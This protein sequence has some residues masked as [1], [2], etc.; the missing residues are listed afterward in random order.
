[1]TLKAKG[2][3]VR[4]IA[5][6]SPAPKTQPCR[7]LEPGEARRSWCYSSGCS[8]AVKADFEKIF[9]PCSPVAGI[10]IRAGRIVDTQAWEQGRF[11]GEQSL[12]GPCLRADQNAALYGQAEQGAAAPA[13]PVVL[14]CP[15][16]ANPAPPGAESNRKAQAGPDNLRT[17]AWGNKDTGH[18]LCKGYVGAPRCSSGAQQDAEEESRG[19]H[20]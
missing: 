8:Q 11:K 1:M 4:S 3:R 20:G 15:W 6:C 18:L 17:R 10:L 7:G 13:L 5:G 16:P 19:Q 2:N 12:P 14:A 9:V